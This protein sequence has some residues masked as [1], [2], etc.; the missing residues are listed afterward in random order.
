MMTSATD[1]LVWGIVIHLIVDWLFQNHWMATY[2]ASLK[3]PA[4]WVH[5][6][7]HT[8]AMLL[9]FPLPIALAIG[10]AHILIDTRKP[11]I[12]WRRFY[13]QTQW[14][15]NSPVIAQAVAVDV[16]MWGDQVVH[17]AVIALAALL[18]VAS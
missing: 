2:K 15:D 14:V 12:W 9:I 18:A 16:M 11:L 3:H 1:Y 7:L 8:A 17:I 6:G 4:A 5:S 13:R 10:A